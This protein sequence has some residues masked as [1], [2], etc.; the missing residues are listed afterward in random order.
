[1]KKLKK[2]ITWFLSFFKKKKQLNRSSFEDIKKE[3]G[4]LVKEKQRNS[5]GGYTKGLKYKKVSSIR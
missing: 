3:V 5:I 4:R 2:F 1:M